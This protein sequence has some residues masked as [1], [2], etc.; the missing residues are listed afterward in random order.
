MR[1]VCRDTA[2]DDHGAAIVFVDAY[3]AP[4]AL[5]TVAEWLLALAA[6]WFLTSELIG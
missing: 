1:P 4:A 6:R 5:L 3:D 2:H